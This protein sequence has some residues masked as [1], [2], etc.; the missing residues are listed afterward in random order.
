MAL[1]RPLYTGVVLYK[2]LHRDRGSTAS[3][4]FSIRGDIRCDM[5][6]V[7]GGTKGFC[8]SH[9]DAFWAVTTYGKMIYGTIT[10]RDFIH[11]FLY[12]YFSFSVL[13][14]A[15]RHP[16]YGPS[17]APLR[18]SQTALRPLALVPFSR[19]ILVEVIDPYGIFAL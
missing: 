12:C 2:H 14:K 10:C 1:L 6:I 17:K 11:G 3:E 15:P 9:S 4:N 13:L 18:L 19:A 16:S 5:W 8:R 7:E